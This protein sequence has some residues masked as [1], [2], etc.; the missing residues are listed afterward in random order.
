MLNVTGGANKTHNELS[1]HI[2][3]SGRRHRDNA[4]PAA[5]EGDKREPIRTTGETV[6]QSDSM[7]NNRQTPQKN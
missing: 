2:G 4:T 3:Q 6:H 5:G 7:E 1:L